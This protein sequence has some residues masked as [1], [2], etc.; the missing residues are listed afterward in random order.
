MVTHS[1]LIDSS[2]ADLPLVR[3]GKV[4]DVYAVDDAHLLIVATDRISAFD[5][6]LGSGIPDKG[7]VLTQL[8][9]FW[10]DRVADLVPHHLV[11]ADVAA[12]PRP[13]WRRTPT[14]LRGRV[15]AR[16]R[17]R[18]RS[19]SSASR[20]ATSPARAGRTTARPARSAASRCRRACARAI[21]CPSRSSRPR[22]R[23][24][25]ATTRTSA[26]RSAAG[27]RRRRH[28]GAA[29]GADAGDLPRAASSTP[30]RAASS[31]PTR[32]SSSASRRDGEARR[33]PAD[34]RGDDARLVAL[35]AGRR[36]RAGRPAAQLRQA[37]R[38]RLPRGD[39]LEQ[40]AAGAVAARPTS[41]RGRA[42]STSTPTAA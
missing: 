7:R 23:P 29:Q 31:S 25:A 22:P 11:T 26:R 42:R 12:L 37:V 17:A 27:D 4:R 19:R 40:A 9:A 15:D 14:L 8:S 28:A 24:R 32:S 10:F 18:R 33:D 20:A 5:F 36:L 2:L 41:S 3:R 30:R 13:R 21:G 6:V 1:P 35:L 16:A 34:R 38:A 39:P